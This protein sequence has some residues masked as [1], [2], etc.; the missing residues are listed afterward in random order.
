[1]KIELDSFMGGWRDVARIARTSTHASNDENRDKKLVRYLYHNQHTS[2]FEF[3]VTR[4]IVDAP[5]FVARQWMR[6]RTWSYSERSARY[7]EFQDTVWAPK[8]WRAQA[9]KNRQASAGSLPQGDEYI[10]DVYQNAVEASV[11]TYKHLI[12]EGVSRE[13]ARAILPQSAYTRFVAQTDMH[14]LMHFLKLRDDEHAQPEIRWYAQEIKK[15]M[16]TIPSL[17]FFVE[18]MEEYDA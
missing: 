12:E 11:N 2:P 4:W 3:V 10:N 7:T 1:M 16:S 13:M 14:N 9:E 6:H 17:Y 8:K 18:L 5:I 15:I